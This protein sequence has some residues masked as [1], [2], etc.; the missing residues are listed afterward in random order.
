MLKKSLLFTVFAA[1][2]ITIPSAALAQIGIQL[3]P[4]SLSS[5]WQNNP[6]VSKS[7]VT[8]RALQT[9]PES[10]ASASTNQ[11]RRDLARSNSYKGTSGTSILLKSMIDLTT[12]APA[13]EA[14]AMAYQPTNSYAPAITSSHVTAYAPVT[15]QAPIETICHS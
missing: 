11:S 15:A 13:P 6:Y 8:K 14:P 9:Q 7:P 10:T 2:A 4:P 1:V 3:P 5:S 12:Y